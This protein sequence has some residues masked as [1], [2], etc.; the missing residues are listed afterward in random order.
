LYR[1][2]AAC[3]SESGGL[4]PVVGLDNSFGS[5]NLIIVIKIAA[6]VA[7]EFTC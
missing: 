7:I 3:V 2:I 5:E 6:E 4:N 1:P